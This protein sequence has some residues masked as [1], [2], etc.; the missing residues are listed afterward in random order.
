MVDATALLQ[1]SSRALAQIDPDRLTSTEMSEALLEIQRLRAR[2]EATEARL[3]A[4]WDADKVWQPSGAKSGAAWLARM[5][6]LPIQVTRERVRHARALRSLQEVDEAWADG[7]VD[8][9]HL[10]TML[11]KRTSRTQHAFDTDHKVLLESARTRGFV[12][13]KRHCDLWEQFVDQDGAEQRAEDGRSARE[14]HLAQSYAGMWFGRITLDPISGEI[15]N[16][17][18][19][20]IERELFEH[21]WAEAKERLGRAPL[22]VELD[23]T[24]AQRR[25]D[26]L[27]EM[28]TRARTA[29]A[30]GK[31]PAPLF[32]VLVG[33]ETFAGP[34][35]ETHNRTTLTPGTA[36]RWLDG[37]DIER[38]VFDGPSRVI[39]VGV[40]RRFYTG[41]LRRA[42]EVRDRT[43]FHPFCDEVPDRVEI[44]HILEH[45][46]GGE[47][48]HD[49]GRAGCGFHNRRRN[50]HPD[51]P[52][53]P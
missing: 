42:I 45:A 4:R 48:T 33:Y 52:D 34:L 31:R 47:T 19:R 16:E 53:P 8:R 10:V 23:R 38:I 25:A 39:D 44:D 18:L 3:L 40:K 24:P 9:S 1:A 28:A 30:D 35:L 32:T 20:Q 50:T 36:A 46:K 29:P 15:V 43:C 5:Q 7:E 2:L 27:V 13:F 37:A 14:L 21:D 41:A 12:D 6:R 11:G 49:N 17:A 51:D 22:I 26:A